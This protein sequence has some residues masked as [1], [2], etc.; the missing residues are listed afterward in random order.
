[1]MLIASTRVRP[2]RSVLAE[3]VQFGRVAREDQDRSPA[4]K[5]ILEKI[6]SAEPEIGNLVVDRRPD[7][8]ADRTGHVRR[9]LELDDSCVRSARC[10]SK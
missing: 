9:S 1:V 10:D 4:K 7:T 6:D 8:N 5:L 2:S 3:L